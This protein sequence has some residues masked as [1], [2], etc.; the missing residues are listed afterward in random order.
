MVFNC[1]GMLIAEI[2]SAPQG[3]PVVTLLIFALS[4]YPVG[5]MLGGSSCQ[6]CCDEGI[7]CEPCYRAYVGG[8]TGIGRFSREQECRTCGEFKGDWILRGCRVI[9]NMSRVGT[10]T[11]FAGINYGGWSNG[12]VTDLM[13]EEG[14]RHGFV[15]TWG[16]CS[17]NTNVGYDHTGVHQCVF[18]NGHTILKGALIVVDFYGPWVTNEDTGRLGVEVKAI[19]GRIQDEGWGGFWDSGLDLYTQAVVWCVHRLGLEE[20]FDR[21]GLTAPR[22]ERKLVYFHGPVT[23]DE[24]GNFSVTMN[25]TRGP[26]GYAPYGREAVQDCSGSITITNIPN[27][28]IDPNSPKSCPACISPYPGYEFSKND[29]NVYDIFGLTQTSISFSG[30]RPLTNPEFC[31]PEVPEFVA[32]YWCEQGDCQCSQWDG[33]Y[34]DLMAD[35]PE[36]YRDHQILVPMNCEGFNKTIVLDF[37]TQRDFW[38]LPITNDYSYRRDGLYSPCTFPSCLVKEDGTFVGRDADGYAF[39]ED[40]GYDSI[41]DAPTLC[42]L[43][44]NPICPVAICGGDSTCDCFEGPC[45][46]G[47]IGFDMCAHSYIPAFKVLACAK[48]HIS[49]AHEFYELDS[50]SDK[51]LNPF[52]ILQY[53]ADPCYSSDVSYSWWEA[54][55]RAFG[56]RWLPQPKYHTY[57]PDNCE[58]DEALGKIFIDGCVDDP[59]TAPSKITT[60]DIF[61]GCISLQGYEYWFNQMCVGDISREITY[62]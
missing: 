41:E 18:H 52:G 50:I 27:P 39:C 4:L 40:I 17:Y 22:K 32:P 6:G 58:Y 26:I 12:D 46:P 30:S 23:P 44:E 14:G 34:P 62:S 19:G 21:S 35:P 3:I 42:I 61:G 8:S 48:S 53:Y 43:D 33:Q 2:V 37:A 45:P 1:F 54:P 11:S 7:D 36:T 57:E 20:V 51:W 38:S 24:N 49:W 47:H 59:R 55:I 29:W 60:R 10:R 9:Y 5:L 16:A 31:R 56:I 28:I 15:N 13:R 25:F